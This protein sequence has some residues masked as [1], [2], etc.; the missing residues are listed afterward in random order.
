MTRYTPMIEVFSEFLG[1]IGAFLSLGS[2]WLLNS[3]ESTLFMLVL[4]CLY[5]AIRRDL[6]MLVLI[7]LVLG[8]IFDLALNL[9]FRGDRAKEGRGSSLR[10]YF[11][12]LG[13]VD[14][15]GFA[16][17]ITAWLVLASYDIWRFVNVRRIWLPFFG[18][19]SGAFFGILAENSVALAPLLPFYKSTS[20]QLENRAWDGASILLVNAIIVFFDIVKD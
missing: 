9:Y 6:S 11:D 20:G 5:I 17:C 2:M 19:L 16:A 7:A 13:P 12:L 3:T 18:F 14:A 8:G 10:A 1:F 4:L 15:A